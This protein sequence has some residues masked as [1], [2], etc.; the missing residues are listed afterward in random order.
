VLESLRPAAFK[1][2]AQVMVYLMR[3]RPACGAW[4]PH[5]VACKVC[6]PESLFQDQGGRGLVAAGD[7]QMRP[8]VA[9]LFQHL[10][11]NGFFVPTW[12]PTRPRWPASPGTLADRIRR[13]EAGWDKE[14]PPPAAIAPRS[15]KLWAD[16]PPMPA[17]LTLAAAVGRRRTLPC[18]SSGACTARAEVLDRLE[19]LWSPILAEALPPAVG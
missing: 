4:W 3:V 9:G 16:R 8:T 14:V 7:I 19:A 1:D 6:L 5:P 2:G 18:R 17:P 15:L 13:G 11:N 12:A 10:L